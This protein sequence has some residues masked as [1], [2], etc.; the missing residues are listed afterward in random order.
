[1]ISNCANS[2]TEGWQDER[3][4][5]FGSVGEVTCRPRKCESE[6]QSERSE[7]V[8]RV[9]NALIMIGIAIMVLLSAF[10]C[11]EAEED[12]ATMDDV[13]KVVFFADEV[14]VVVPEMKSLG[15][16]KITAY[17]SCEKCC[18]G[19]AKKRPK[20]KNGNEIIVGAT[21][22]VLESGISIAVDKTVIPYGTKVLI[23][24]KEYIA[25]DCGGAIKGNRIDV[26]HDSHREAKEF[27]VQ[28]TEVFMKG[29]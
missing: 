25:Q 22:E 21:G 2:T 8:K 14:E 13:T 6:I 5:D 27:G 3:R 18:D 16:F 29:E 4:K 12:L 19:W 17:C 9:R 28:Y 15:R 23:D 11:A 7:E 26:Y 20:D 24:G 10:L 1:M